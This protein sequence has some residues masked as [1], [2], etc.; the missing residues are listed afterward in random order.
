M[1]NYLLAACQ[2]GSNIQNYLLRS[3]IN[4]LSTT[5]RTTFYSLSNKQI[6]HFHQ[7]HHKI[8]K[9]KDITTIFV[10]SVQ[11]LKFFL[12]IS[13]NLCTHFNF[14]YHKTEVQQSGSSSNVISCRY[15]YKSLTVDI[16]YRCCHCPVSAGNNKTKNNNTFKTVYNKKTV[17]YKTFCTHNKS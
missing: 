2:K 14:L 16:Y 11:K 5:M 3:Y 9:Y 4:N 15:V 8:Y 12:Y 1:C 6:K 7:E 10:L 13:H 17:K